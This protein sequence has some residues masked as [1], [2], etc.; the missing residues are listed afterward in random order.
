MKNFMYYKPKQASTVSHF[1]FLALISVILTAI[2]LSAIVQP[3][4]AANVSL[5]SWDRVDAGKHLDWDGSTNYMPQFENA[6]NTWNSY[7]SGVI[8]KDTIWIIQDVAISDYY[9]GD[10]AYVALA[11]S[12]GKIKFNQYYMDTYTNAQK[13]NICT[14]MLGYQ[15]GLGDSY[16]PNDVMYVDT[17]SITALSANDKAS[18]D[19]AYNK[20]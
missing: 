19:A 18:Y 11:Y 15:L 1:V 9:D 16:N 20:Y 3:A 4:L 2:L 10:T 13:Q 7:K 6:V 17:T 12:N 5:N 14:G 8:R